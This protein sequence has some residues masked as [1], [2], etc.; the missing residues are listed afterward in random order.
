MREFFIGLLVGVLLTL[1]TVWYFAIGR[2]RSDIRH[3][4][5]TTAATVQRAATV[6]AIEAT[7]TAITA[8]LKAKF[9]AEK[10]LTGASIAV[11]TDNGRVAL[12]GTVT[13]ADQIT[14]VTAIARETTGVRDVTANLQVRK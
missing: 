14:K 13:N 11:V 7:D 4:Q 9:L 8:K 2:N 10:S 6:T 5:D 12:A 1:A 3:A